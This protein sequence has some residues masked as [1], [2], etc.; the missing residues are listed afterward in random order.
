MFPGKWAKESPDKAATIDTSDGAI[1][2]YKELDDR[3]NQFAQY[4]WKLGLRKGDHLAI[5]MENNLTYLDVAWAALRSGLYVT[6]ISRYLTT[7]EAA[8]I[9]NDSGARVLVSTST[10]EEVASALPGQATKCERFLAVGNEMAGYEDFEAAIAGFA[11]EPLEQQPAGEFMLYSSGTTGQPKG[12]LRP[13]PDRTIDGAGNMLAALQSQ[14]WG[15]TSDTVYLS[16]APLYHSAP[17]A[18]CVTV[19]ALGG[20]VVVMPR[21]DERTALEAI[22]RWR[23]THSQ[24]VPTMFTRMLK[25]PE[26]ER[27][28]WDLSSHRVAVHAAAPCPREVKHKMFDWWGPILH[29]YYA[30]TE[31]NGLTH[32]GPQ[33]WLEHPGTVGKAV[34]GALH[35]CDEDGNELPIG[36]AGIV[37][38]ELPAI[39][40]QYLND[41]EKTREAQHPD[42]P[43][44]SK[45]GDLGYMDEDG[46]LY[47]TDRAAFMIISGGVNI[48]PQEIEDAIVMH[49][50]VEDVAVIGIPN[51]DMGEEVKAI[52]QVRPGVI[53][54]K[55]LE[56]ELIAYARA[57]IAHYKCPRSVDFIDKLPRQPTGK[58]FKRLLRDQYWAE[59]GSQIVSR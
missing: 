35:I 8:Y 55:A 4:L 54:D 29:E 25:L 19:H 43:N 36:V 57:R 20:T 18:S 59:S 58:L 15:V 48:Y 21:F 9:V 42:H 51:P 17:I 26:E 7:D 39:P 28:K 33:E 22:E 27:L 6:T 23:I 12:I 47:L 44:W 38:F 3:S 41:P 32:V 53:S 16:P 46:F 34:L 14:F 10:L 30:G 11:P 45:L 37:Y 56:K 50:S 2:T 52:V 13:L 24:W 40:F 31:I 49:S 1:R 5:F